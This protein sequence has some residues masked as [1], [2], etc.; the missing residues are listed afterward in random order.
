MGAKAMFPG[1]PMDFD[2][3]QLHKHFGRIWPLHVEGFTQLLIDLRR[4]FGGDLDRM[5]VLAI[6]GSRT[7][8]RRRT[9][10]LSYDDFL[11]SRTHDRNP[12]RIN[13]Q[14][15]A[16]CSG[17]PRET[18]RRKVR[19]L[20][21]LGWLIREGNGHLRVAEQAARD[22]QPATEATLE[23]LLTIGS[24]CVAAARAESAPDTDPGPEP[25][26]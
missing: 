8:P 10:G 1:I 3:A 16:E 9:E 22:L 11:A 15:I 12:G 6:I 5:L 14:S 21:L 24:A 4:H 23:Y 20:E 19:E 13:V 7:L 25:F 17:I 18:V 2:Y 26:T